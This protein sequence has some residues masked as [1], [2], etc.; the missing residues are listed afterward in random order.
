[1]LHRSFTTARGGCAGT[2]A[3]GSKAW[4]TPAPFTAHRNI[5]AA[6][7]AAHTEGDNAAAPSVSSACHSDREG[8]RGQGTCDES[9]ARHVT[10]G[11]A[12]QQSAAATALSALLLLSP[13]AQ[14]G[15]AHA[16]LQSPNAQIARSVDAALRRSI[17]AFNPVAAKLQKTLEEIQYLLRCFKA[18]EG[19]GRV[20][21]HMHGSRT[22]PTER[23]LGRTFGCL[24]FPFAPLR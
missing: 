10:L 3:A 21:L 13:M 8:R 16:V 15:P 14:P 24:L 5:A 23:F 6:A 2:A 17:P 11:A 1:M 9:A 19:S 22:R 20:I 4:A 18:W 12:A 7:A